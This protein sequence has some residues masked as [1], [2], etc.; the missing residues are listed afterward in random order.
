MQWHRQLASAPVL[1]CE[2]SVL[3]GFGGNEVIHMFGGFPV[4]IV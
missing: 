1:L 3:S 2:D 4:Y